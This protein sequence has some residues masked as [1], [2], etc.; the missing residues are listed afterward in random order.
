MKFILFSG[1]PSCSVPLLQSVMEKNSFWSRITALI[2]VVVLPL[3]YFLLISL[4]TSVQSSSTCLTHKRTPFSSLFSLWS[5]FYCPS[6]TQPSYFLCPV[7]PP[8]PPGPTRTRPLNH[9][10]CS[11]SSGTLHKPPV[12]TWAQLDCLLSLTFRMTLQYCLCS[13]AVDLH[14][15]LPESSGE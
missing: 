7:F 11:C 6:L 10:S 9:L 13:A 2:C 15:G 12:T 8:S 14:L 3:I 1:I 4:F 5:R